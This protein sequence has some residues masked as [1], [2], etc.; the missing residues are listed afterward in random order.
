MS[1]E[2][3]SPVTKITNSNLFIYFKLNSINQFHSKQTLD[4]LKKFKQNSY[5]LF[6]Q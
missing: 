6:H 2:K 1:L 5:V 4:P 3:I